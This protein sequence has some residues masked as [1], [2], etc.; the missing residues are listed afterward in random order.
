MNFV[1]ETIISPEQELEYANS[2]LKEK[3][4]GEVSDCLTQLAKKVEDLGLS[5]NDKSNL[6]KKLK[7]FEDVYKE[8]DIPGDQKPLVERALQMAKES[9]K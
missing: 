2:A 1:R 9:L 7:D 5:E 3:N 6:S 8:A 4:W